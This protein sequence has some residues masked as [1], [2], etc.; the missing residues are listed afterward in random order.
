[1]VEQFRKL[2]ADRLRPKTLVNYGNPRPASDIAAMFCEYETKLICG[3]ESQVERFT[4]IRHMA[5]IEK[6]LE[7]LQV[8]SA[9][10]SQLRREEARPNRREAILHSRLR[11]KRRAEGKIED[12]GGGDGEQR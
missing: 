10:I 6:E 3:K 1:M 5:D 7:A 12:G 8:F 9:A 11:K 2:L 4:L